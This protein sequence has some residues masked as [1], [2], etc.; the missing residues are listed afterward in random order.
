MGLKVRDAN[1]A[2]E[3]FKTKAGAAAG[4]YSKGIEGSGG[5][6]ES[7]AMSGEQNYAD[8]VS[9]AIG[10]GAFGKGVKNSGGAYYEMRAKTLGVTRYAPG[11]QAGAANYAEGVAPFLDAMRSATLSPRRPKGD[12]GNFQRVQDIAN[13]NRQVKLRR[14]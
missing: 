14:A 9:A 8:G 10:R 3:R 4:D 12:P 2:A 11:V 7:G 5:A 6:W 1:A 13:L